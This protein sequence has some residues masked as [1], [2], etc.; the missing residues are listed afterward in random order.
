MKGGG[1][2]ILDLEK[3]IF[4]GV[5]TI[6]ARCTHFSFKENIVLGW[7][8][9]SNLLP[10]KVVTDTRYFLLLIVKSTVKCC[11]FIFSCLFAPSWPRISKK[12]CSVWIWVCVMH[13]SK[14]SELRDKLYGS[15]AHCREYRCFP[16]CKERSLCFLKTAL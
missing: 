15:I 2:H 6:F 11:W 16:G 13:H 10:K 1:L 8:Q 14:I 3:S 12:P 9:S 5:P 7:N 4:W